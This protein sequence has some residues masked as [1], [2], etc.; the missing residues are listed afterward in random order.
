MY[1]LNNTLF[2]F[3][4][5]F[6]LTTVLFSLFLWRIHQHSPFH[7]THTTFLRRVLVLTTVICGAILWCGYFTT[8]RVERNRVQQIREKA[9]L[10]SSVL[11]TAVNGT[12]SKITTGA[13]NL[14][15]SS[16]VISFLSDRSSPSYTAA[17]TVLDRY[18]R[19]FNASVV[20]L[21]DTNGTTIA[22]S[23]RYD[24]DSF[25]GKN[26]AFRPYFSKARQGTP[27]S[28]FAVGVTSGKRGF[29][30]SA[31][32][33]GK[34]GSIT[35]VA[36]I[37]H[38]LYE[39]DSLFASVPA[40]FLVDKNDI[41]FV[42][43]ARKQL[44]RPLFPPTDNMPAVYELQRQYGS[45]SDAPILRSCPKSDVVVYR[46]ARYFLTKASLN[47]PDCSVVHLSPYHPVIQYRLF[48]VLA[49]TALILIILIIISLI[50]LNRI[51]DFSV[52]L[53]LSEKRFQ[54]IFENA[55]EA[56]IIVEIANGSII[57]TNPLAF[58]IMSVIT[59]EP[60]SLNSFITKIN[61]PQPLS[62]P[63]S[64]ENL[65]GLFHL[66][67]SDVPKTLSVSSTRI[68]FGEKSCLLCFLRDI[69]S[70][71]ETQSA[72]KTSERKYREL[73][74]FLPEGVFEV[75]TEGGIMYTN[76]R[77]CDMFGYTSDVLGEA[78]TLFDLF[79]PEE[80]EMVKRNFTKAMTDRIQSQHE[81]TAR[82]KNGELFKA[83]VYSTTIIR[84]DKVTGLCG[85]IIDLTE[86][87]RTEQELQ[88]KDKLE[89]LGIMAGGI[90]HDFNNLLTAIWSGVSLIKLKTS[91]SEE[92]QE[93]IAKIETA[94]RRGKD[95]T[96]QLLTYSKGG[97]PVKTATSLENLLKE[98]A[99][100]VTSGTPVKCEFSIDT[101]LYAAD[102]DSGQISQ[103]IQN[104]LLNAIDAMPE[105]GVI[106]LSIRNR[107]ISSDDNIPVAPGKYLELLC[108]DT[109]IGVS[110]EADRRIFD[111]FF[112][113][114]IKGSG[115]GLFTSYSIVKKH[116]GHISF[117]NNPERGT[118][119][120]ILLPAT[121]NIL[122]KKTAAV[123][124]VPEGNGTILLMDDEAI[125]L[126]VTSKLLKYLGYSVI[127]TRSGEEVLEAY[128][129]SLSI[130]NPIDCVILDLTIPAGMGGKE[131]MAELLKIDP[132]V[133]VI[134]S[135]G[136]S[137]DPIMARYKAFGFSSV[138][139][140]PYDIHDLNSVI[141]SVISKVPY[142]VRE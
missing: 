32:V 9:T 36:V 69:S 35:G 97:A 82:R 47:M 121:E 42:S 116:A 107:L 83:L 70:I 11:R 45:F 115:L 48:G 74:D 103:V 30:R 92:D 2:I 99:S 124:N 113:T 135:S 71:I 40:V 1:V 128:S 106:T 125:I 3:V 98:T 4:A 136:Y 102:I 93:T 5:I 96:G 26:Y 88:K 134:V 95:L 18:C 60:S 131:T 49:T 58:E 105:G 24:D 57:A 122:H 119:F 109:G 56:I 31:P 112:S 141:Q 25:L 12:I 22:S 41:V 53:Y 10:I 44:Y 91:S 104:L 110:M 13:A 129:K 137:N 14:A 142:P 127:T 6:V 138:I 8:I 117:E 15:G 37:K 59:D 132:D 39:I 79:T 55:P 120:H 65:Q 66:R 118:T 34:N 78:M 27:F 33:Y 21:L 19:T 111:P 64:P 72:L 108:S 7:Y 76:K 81:Y 23:N 73:A 51:N 68:L 16:P 85:I 29:Y 50:A 61:H 86:R 43:S 94:I 38:H 54:T 123:K 20:Y 89:A 126:K 28:Y 63:L 87:I 17:S 62:T 139:S 101:D 75:N 130:G 133:K 100:F 84:E 67:S 140:K 114:K 90:A 77:G 80:R 52:S 46:N